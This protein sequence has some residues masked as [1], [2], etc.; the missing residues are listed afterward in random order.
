MKRGN[1]ND[2]A[3]DEVSRRHTLFLAPN[4]A[5]PLGAALLRLSLSISRS[6]MGYDAGPRA[7]PQHG[8]GFA[9]NA[10]RTL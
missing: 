9:E 8:F 1:V 6:T 5:L 7:E 3:V 4:M 10:V 2:R